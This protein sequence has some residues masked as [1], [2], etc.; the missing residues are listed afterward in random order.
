MITV[1][2]DL[3]SRSYNIYIG[4]GILGGLGSW[5][6]EISSGDKALL[7]SNR[8]VFD[9]Y[10]EIVSKSLASGGFEVICGEMGDGEEYKNL[11]MLEKL[12]DTAFNH[13]MDRRC[14]VVALGGGV[15]GDTA[16]LAAAVYLRG[17]PFVQV[18]TTLLAQVDSS[19]GGKVAVN[20][21]GG[22]NIIGAFYQPGL[23]V[24]DMAT[25][26]TLP[27]REIKSGLAELIKYG[28]ISDAG[29]FNW[30]EENTVKL[31]SLDEEALAHAAAVA[32]R[33]KARVV[34]ADE[35]EQGLRA[36]L[37]FGHT[38]GHAVEALCGYGVYSHGEAVAAGMAAAARLAQALGLLPAEQ[39]GRVVA[40][41]RRAGLPVSLPPYLDR[42]D[43]IA[44]MRQDKKARAGRLTLVLPL[45][46]GR[47][48]VLNDIS[49]AA[50]KEVLFSGK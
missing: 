25:L 20:H 37:N 42:D 5:V 18:P 44:A 28:V 35:T 26:Q 13:K 45:E 1:R 22:K 2:V 30:L 4:S 31:L 48:K 49:E 10:G 19:V 12:C 6:R 14:P 16:G 40:L 8:K 23:V 11:D 46:I 43:I 47:V 32:C 27:L 21:P 29:F 17:V 3:G 39:A 7:V 34:E 36:I 50:V 38:V 15:V 24:A 33:T 9:L 41:I